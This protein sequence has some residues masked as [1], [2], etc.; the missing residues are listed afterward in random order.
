MS[1]TCTRAHQTPIEALLLAP[2]SDACLQF[3]QHCEAC[4]SC[5]A[6][7]ARYRRRTDA[8]RQLRLGAG[9]LALVLALLAAGAW[10]WLGARRQ[11]A[12][13]E[14]P[15]PALE[16]SA[17][18]ARSAPPTAAAGAPSLAAPGVAG[19]RLVSGQQARI[20]AAS[21]PESGP[22]SFT[23]VL[24]EPSAD[25]NPLRA[26]VRNERGLDIETQARIETADRLEARLEVDAGV[27]SPGVYIL[28]IHT[29]E[30][31]HMPLRRY[32]IEIS[33]GAADP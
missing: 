18:D 13:S 21:L 8:Q 27:L 20:A 22:V 31:S 26:H 17:A 30:R 5:A 3:L 4:D 12:R 7:L 11:P 14:Q 29:T 9:A 32:A 19:R 28:E 1:S 25:A 16:S 33:D 2:D 10:L 15:T 24:P 6:E 23:L